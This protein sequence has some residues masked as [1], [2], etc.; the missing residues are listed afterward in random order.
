MKTC[1]DRHGAVILGLLSFKLSAERI[2]LLMMVVVMVVV[3]VTAQISSVS[4]I[5]SII[6]ALPQGDL[7]TLV[8]SSFTATS[9]LCWC[10]GGCWELLGAF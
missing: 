7:N 1:N 9:G 8:I 5:G 10:F 6:D 4:K 3:M 2:G